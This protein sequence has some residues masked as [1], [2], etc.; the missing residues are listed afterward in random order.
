LLACVKL[1]KEMTK[2]SLSSTGIWKIS[3]LFISIFLNIGKI[4]NYELRLGAMT[5]DNKK[6][7]HRNS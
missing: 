5:R 2:G 3:T 4:T 1:P 7:V 6:T